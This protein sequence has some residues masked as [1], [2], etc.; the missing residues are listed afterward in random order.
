[1]EAATAF[2]W[3]SSYRSTEAADFLAAN[4]PKGRAR[5]I[6]IGSQRMVK[7]AHNRRMTENEGKGAVDWQFSTMCN[8]GH[9]L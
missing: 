6:R 7:A 1:M 8:N 5:D 9:S 3:N 4:D 2:E